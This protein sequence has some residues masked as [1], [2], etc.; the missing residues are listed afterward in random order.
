MYSRPQTSFGT[1]GWS[2]NVGPLMS[3]LTTDSRLSGY[4]PPFAIA[5]SSSE[6]S[7]ARMSTST[8]FLEANANLWS[9]FG[10]TD[11]AHTTRQTTTTAHIP[12]RIQIHGLRFGSCPCSSGIDAASEGS[13]A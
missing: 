12:A 8:F 2:R 11:L 7:M 5:Y 1:W 9:T 3:G 6:L 13:I 4:L 10:A